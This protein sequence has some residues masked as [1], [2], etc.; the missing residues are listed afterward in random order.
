[1]LIWLM[2]PYHQG[3]LQW[4]RGN[5]KCPSAMEQ[6]LMLWVN[7]PA[8]VKQ[9]N[10]T[11]GESCTYFQGYTLGINSVH[12][13]LYYNSVYQKESTICSPGSVW[14]RILYQIVSHIPCSLHVTERSS[15]ARSVKMF[16]LCKKKSYILWH[17]QWKRNLN[18]RWMGWFIPA[19]N[20]EN[21]LLDTAVTKIC[22]TNPTIIEIDYG[23]CMWLFANA[24]VWCFTNPCRKLTRHCKF[25]WG[26]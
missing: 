7:R 15:Q 20:T 1:M 10:V 9:Q 22:L 4:Q 26:E 12:S 17:L 18:T 11:K 24:K 23:M 14:S 16:Q 21:V 13:Q 8:S 25:G 3:F 5:H 19:I 2:Y 6:A